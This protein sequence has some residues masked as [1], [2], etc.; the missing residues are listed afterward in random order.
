MEKRWKN[1]GL[2]GMTILLFSGGRALAE[3][4]TGDEIIRRME[5]HRADS[6]ITV[7][8]MTIVHRSGARR[9]RKMKTWMRGDDYVKVRFLSPA[10]VEGTGFLSVG[11]DSWLY[12]PV[13]RS[14]RRIAAREKGGS[15]MGSDFTYE[16]VGGGFLL[17]DYNATLLGTEEYEGHYCYV[18][19]LLPKNPEDVSYSKLMVWV[20]KENFYLIKVEYYDKHGNLL[21]VLS[22]S[23]FEKIDELWI[24]KRMEMQNKKEGGKTIIVL[25]EI[26]VNPAIPNRIF[27]TR[28]L[29]RR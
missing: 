6:M 27:T 29:E 24:P 3:E 26:E 13:L 4:L 14:V 16:D 28:Q 20:E 5:E 19:K 2:L 7:S 23:E 9:V 12:L 18:L 10:D 25:K 15:F 1:I 8:E 11:D 21:R 17:D 22:S